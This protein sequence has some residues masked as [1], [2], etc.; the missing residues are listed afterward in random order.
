MEL[1]YAETDTPHP[2]GAFCERR[3]FNAYTVCRF[4]TPFLYESSGKLLR[5]ERGEV[6]LMTPGAVV[7]HGPL[8]GAEKGFVNDWMRLRGDDFGGLLDRYPLPLNTAFSVGGGGLLH[9]CI[10]RLIQE[11]ALRGIGVAEKI[12][13]ILTELVIDLHRA[14][15]SRDASGVL[16]AQQAMRENPG[17]PFSLADLARIAGYSVSH[18]CELYRRQ[19][20]IS[21]KHGLLRLRLDHARDMLA[22]SD[23]AIG[24]IGAICGFGDLYH[25]S[26]YFKKA[27]G[28][29]PSAFRALHRQ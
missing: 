11:R 22:Y 18:F 9:A 10:R 17:T 13:A 7:Y 23:A 3:R 6:L 16:R 14:Y 2:V 27:V 12:G 28:L 26:A 15:E 29:S 20:G 24:A 25:F 4:D 5:G 21:P 8:P 19:Y 1:L